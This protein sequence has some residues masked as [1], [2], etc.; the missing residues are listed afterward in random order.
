MRDLAIHFGSAHVEPDANKASSRHRLDEVF[1]SML[2]QA[3]NKE[4]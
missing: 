1:K 4:L 3:F 2:Y